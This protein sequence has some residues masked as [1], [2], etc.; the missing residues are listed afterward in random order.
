MLEVGTGV[1]VASPG[2]P[3]RIVQAEV[4]KSRRRRVMVR[5]SMI[6]LVVTGNHGEL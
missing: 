1:E 5:F 4:M 2:L 3:P 6:I